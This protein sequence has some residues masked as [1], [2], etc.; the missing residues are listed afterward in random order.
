MKRCWGRAFVAACMAVWVGACSDR[1]APPF[2]AQMAERVRPMAAVSSSITPAQFF[3][4]AQ[5]AFPSLFPVGATD[6]RLVDGGISYTYRQYASTDIYLLV[7]E[8]SG[9]IYGYGAVTGNLLAPLGSLNDFAC[10]VLKTCVRVTPDA[11]GNLGAGGLRLIDF[12]V[13]AGQ[14]LTFDGLTSADT[15]IEV[16][17]PTLDSATLCT[18]TT[19]PEGTARAATIPAPR[20]ADPYAGNRLSGPYRTYPAGLYAMSPGT[21]ECGL[22]ERDG[23]CQGNTETTLTSIV[24]ADG[25][26][27]SLCAVSALT[28]QRLPNPA[29]VRGRVL[30]SSWADPGIQGVF[31]RLSWNDIQPKGY[32]Q[33]NWTALD[34]EL[35]QAV[36]YG[37][38][39]TLGIRVGANSI[40][41]WVFTSGHPQLGPA[42]PYQLRDWDTGTN[43]IP[44][45][46][47]GIA[48]TVA[49]PADPAYRAL[50]NKALVDLAA[51]LRADERRFAHVAGVKVTGLAQH[52]LENRLP[53]RC[54][55]A[56]P[57]PAL[58]D[59]GTQGHIVSLNSVNL[60]SPQFDGRYSVTG[61]P[62]TG[63]I[64]DTSLCV[65]NPQ[66]MAYA[67]YKPSTVLAFYNE[68]GA[69]LREGFG[70]KQ[71]IFMNISEGFP[72]VGETGRFD[73]DHLVPPILSA[74]LPLTGT[75]SYVLGTV[76]S[77]VARAP[78]DIPDPNDIT[79]MLLEAG[80]MGAFAGN[81][82]TEGRQF[83]VENAALNPIGFASFAAAGNCAQQTGVASSGTFAGSAAFP[84]APNTPVDNGELAC[85]NT[86]ATRE[87]VAYDKVTGFQVRNSLT[88]ATEVDAALWNMTLNTNG[89]FFEY[90]ESDVWVTRKQAAKNAGMA[91]NPAPAVQR[92]PGTAGASAATPKSGVQWN[93][94]LL[95]RAAAFSAD[96]RH[97]NTYQ[98]NPYPSS[99]TVAVSSEPGANRYVFNSRACRAWA[100]RGVPVRINRITILD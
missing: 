75:P 50:F 87:G 18:A 60:Q 80:R 10:D 64:R 7:A 55:I 99:Y 93:N 97:A 11:D 68:V 42:T 86:L 74:V 40:P 73:G 23:A 100:E 16:A 31:V 57:N 61:A 92:D 30:E 90:Y 9:A 77:S 26:V 6:Q 3:D 34:R 58:G 36:R 63:R 8:G 66:V 71:M 32:G 85:P 72:R 24:R 78:A 98:A 27:D 83:G 19:L 20:S 33:Y 82:S 53:K 2:V 94:L 46:N 59:S 43:D 29:C 91:F 88:G 51:H 4:W 17:S 45:A 79:S 13:R 52:T 41:D 70:H 44:D 38:A 81:S 65:C 37:K 47:C 25:G 28:A 69:T 22:V 67:G 76:R 21:D 14:P 35:A 48:Y 1:P 96:P 15:V 12:T 95:A 54:N 89:L 5:T 49:S 62:A 56:R 84:I 39:V